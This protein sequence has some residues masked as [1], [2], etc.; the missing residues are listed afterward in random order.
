MRSTEISVNRCKT[1]NVSTKTTFVHPSFFL[2][3][4]V[5]GSSKYDA[6]KMS[7]SHK[8]VVTGHMSISSPIASTSAEVQLH[9]I[10]DPW[11]GVS[12]YFLGQPSDLKGSLWGKS[13]EM[14]EENSQS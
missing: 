5:T 14:A 3:L 2:V 10:H 6:P 4:K 9:L 8:V 7:L 13:L 1:V 12:M 11:L